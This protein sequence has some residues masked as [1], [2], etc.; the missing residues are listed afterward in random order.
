MGSDVWHLFPPFPPRASGPPRGRAGGARPPGWLAARHVAARHHQ[1]HGWHVQRRPRHGLR[2]LRRRQEGHRGREPHG[3]VCG[4]RRSVCVYGW[5]GVG[6]GV[7]MCVWVCVFRL[8]FSLSVSM[9]RLRSA[10]MFL[11]EFY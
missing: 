7:F 2:G 1:Q 4:G 10:L 9:L 11:K 3:Y 6:V 5:M 8:T